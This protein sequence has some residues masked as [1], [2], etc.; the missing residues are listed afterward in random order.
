MGEKLLE[1]KRL[2]LRTFEPGDLEPMVRILGD[3][4]V[5]KYLPRGKPRTREEVRE[6]IRT[7]SED[8]EAR[9]YGI[10]AVVQKQTG[11]LIGYCGIMPLADTGEVELAYGLAR[12]SWGKGYAPE[13]ARAMLKHG[14]DVWGFK[15]IVAL[16][17]HENTA[18]Q[19]VLEKIGT[20]YEKDAHFYDMDVRYFSLEPQVLNM[21]HLAINFAE[22]LDKFSEL[23]SPKI[24][25]Q[26]NDYHFKL[27]KI[28]GEFVWH[29]HAETDE[30]FIVLKGNMAIELRDRVVE[31][32]AGEMYVVPKGVEH[33]PFAENECQIMLIE[34]AGTKN[35]GEAVSEMTAEDA[36]WI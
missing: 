5:T 8:Y 33:K 13:A 16:T 36:V 32:K 2:Y 12:A 10:G 18:S 34:P 15:R 14:L 24:I 9:G 19:K 25:A 21:K 27:A 29:S 4:E 23:W 31:L 17:R 30:V 3:A 28:R 22:K 7:F 20:R 35:T 11:E 6:R 26:M 1:T